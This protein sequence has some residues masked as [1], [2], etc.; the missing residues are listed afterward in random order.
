M[1]RVRGIEG[2]AAARMD[3]DGFSIDVALLPLKLPQTLGRR[4]KIYAYRAHG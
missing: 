3:I 1:E 2:L 4:D